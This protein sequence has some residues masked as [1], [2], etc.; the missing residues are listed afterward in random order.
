MPVAIVVLDDGTIPAI[1]VEK[2]D[3]LLAA[4]L[5]TLNAAEEIEDPR[6]ARLWLSSLPEPSGWFENVEEAKA[7]VAR[8]RRPSTMEGAELRKIREALGMTRAEFAEALGFKGNENTRHKQIFEMENG[9][10]P[11]MS[12]R[13]RAA[14]A[15]A[16]GTTLVEAGS[17]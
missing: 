12:E 5:A 7:F 13:A 2:T 8:T 1:Y 9:A 17:A 10:K 11:I 14:R 6:T 3:A 4:R 15:L 16:A